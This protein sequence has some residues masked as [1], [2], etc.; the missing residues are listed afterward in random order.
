MQLWLN[1][2]GWMNR[3]ATHP[4]SPAQGWPSAVSLKNWDSKTYFMQRKLRNRL[5]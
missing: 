5:F 2:H 1:L 4:I 3:F